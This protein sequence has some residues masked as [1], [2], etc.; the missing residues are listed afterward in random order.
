M[1]NVQVE[2]VRGP[3][4]TVSRW[5]VK[6]LVI[7]AHEMG[8]KPRSVIFLVRISGKMVLNA[9]LNSTKASRHNSPVSP[10]L[11]YCHPDG[12]P[13]SFYSPF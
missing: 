3:T 7:Q 1:L 2:D 5:S 13:P 10:A 4:L 11:G 9:E 12:F 8:G 6:K